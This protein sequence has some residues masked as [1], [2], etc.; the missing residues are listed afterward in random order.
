M[1]ERFTFP[2]GVHGALHKREQPDE[3]AFF[4]QDPEAHAP[5][6]HAI[7][8]HCKTQLGVEMD[9]RKTL[10]DT[11][12]VLEYTPQVRGAKTNQALLYKET[13]DVIQ[14]LRER[15]E[16]G[17][18][19]SETVAGYIRDHP[20]TNIEVHELLLS[21]T[22]LDAK[23]IR[24]AVKKPLHSLPAS[25]AILASDMLC[26]MLAGNRRPPKA[27]LNA[28]IK[29]DHERDNLWCIVKLAMPAEGA[30]TKR[31]FV[32]REI[33]DALATA[34]QTQAHYLE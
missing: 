33:Y 24:Q 3:L 17:V 29:D 16:P 22:V 6:A 27:P 32:Q 9:A 25:E 2:V 15:A 28:D 30:D 34:Y 20:E 31:Q 5:V 4:L 13:H 21:S 12:T 14:E 1:S 19:M 11:Y 8:H 18:D 26:T 7:N 10:D 23:T